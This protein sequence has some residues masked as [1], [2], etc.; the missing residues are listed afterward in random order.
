LLLQSNVV[1]KRK[2]NANIDIALNIILQSNKLFN[3]QSHSAG[4]T[5]INKT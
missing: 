3:T 5:Y 4:I 2:T 1:D